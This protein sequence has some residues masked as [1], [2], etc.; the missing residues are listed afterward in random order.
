MPKVEY[1][2]NSDV[3]IVRDED[4]V[5]IG[6]VGDPDEVPEWCRD[7]PGALVTG[8]HGYL[9]DTPIWGSAD[10][11]MEMEEAGILEL[12]PTRRVEFG[13]HGIWVYESQV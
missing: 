9:F 4:D 7:N 12:R 2:P 3:Q 1:D 6:F 11:F 5:V 8:R 10:T 13:D